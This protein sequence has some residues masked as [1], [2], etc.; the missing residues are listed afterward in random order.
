M[1]LPQAET[2]KLQKVTK[3][4]ELLAKVAQDPAHEGRYLVA[5]EVVKGDKTGYRIHSFDDAGDARDFRDSLPEGQRCPSA[6]PFYVPRKG[7]SGLLCG[8]ALG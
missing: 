7:E 5:E 3:L 8:R 6:Q 1:G 4:S 2:A